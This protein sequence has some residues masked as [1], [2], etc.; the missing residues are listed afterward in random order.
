MPWYD[1]REWFRIGGT[2][3]DPE[4]ERSKY[5]QDPELM[6][7]EY[8][9]ELRRR[10]RGEGFLGAE[11]Q[12]KRGAA[13]Q[14]KQA[15]ALAYGTPGVRLGQAQRAAERAGDV[16]DIYGQQT[17]QLAREQ[18]RYAAEQ[19]LGEFLQAQAQTQQQRA[20]LDALY[21]QM[22]FGAAEADFLAEQIEKGGFFGF[23]GNIIGSVL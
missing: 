12:A 23:L 10:M 6:S 11:E 1:P 22:G 21:A 7:P 13:Q 19:A 18:D 16:A 20:A 5:Y 9:E 15:Q 8:G 2:G 14:R 17:A 3:F 4:E